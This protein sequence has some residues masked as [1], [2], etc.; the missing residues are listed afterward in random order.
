MSPATHLLCG[1]AA[2]A[3]TPP[4]LDALQ[5]SLCAL[6]DTYRAAQ[7]A[8]A[9]YGTHCAS[10]CVERLVRCAAMKLDDLTSVV[11]AALGSSV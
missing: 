11:Q 6:L 1:G 4:L 9:A 10:Q 5:R 3:N 8:L 2:S 7:E